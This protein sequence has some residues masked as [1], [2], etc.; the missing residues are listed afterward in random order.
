MMIDFITANNLDIMKKNAQNKG[1]EIKSSS[2]DETSQLYREEYSEQ[3]DSDIFQILFSQEAYH[4]I[5]TT[6]QE[7][8]ALELLNM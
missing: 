3:E 4:C 2:P 6:T 8:V 5:I 7:D 1:K